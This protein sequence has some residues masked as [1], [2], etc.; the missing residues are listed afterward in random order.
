MDRIYTKPQVKKH[1]QELNVCHQ[2][3]YDYNTERQ[4]KY[5]SIMN[6]QTYKYLKEIKWPWDTMRSKKIQQLMYVYY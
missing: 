4:R 3:V 5:E 2:R 6:I 1:L